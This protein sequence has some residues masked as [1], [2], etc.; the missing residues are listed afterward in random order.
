MN[1]LRACALLAL[2]AT[3]L[4]AC[5]GSQP[6]TQADAPV[7]GHTH[8]APYLSTSPV[9]TPTPN[10]QKLP[11]FRGPAIHT[12]ARPL[13]ITAN[14]NLVAL[15]ML[16]ITAGTADPNLDSAR[17]MLGQSGVPFDVLD[18]TTTPLTEDS[19]IAGADGSGRYQGVILTN[20]AL[21]Y[22]TD[23]GGW[24]SALSATEW[25][26]LWQYERTYHARQLSLY[27][28]P[29]SWPEDYGL[30]YV[31][32]S[33][34]DHADLSVA[35]AGG[36]VL[37]DLRAGTS[38][39]VRSAWNYPATVTPA[40]GVASVQPILTDAQGR[41][42]G[43]LSSAADGR[44]RLALTFA[45]NQYLLHTELLGADLVNWVTR[46][47]YLGEYRRYNQLDIDDWFLANDR[48][49]PASGNVLPDATRMAPSDA[50]SLRDQ[51]NAI[52]AGYDT[53]RAFRF[54]IFFNGGGANTGAPKSC[55]P[56]VGGPD[57]LTS[58]SKCL[59]GTFDWVSHT[60][61]HEY[62]DSLNYD[63]SYQQLA[64]NNSIGA[65][66]GLTRSAG[67]LTTGDMSGLGYY[68]KGGDGPKTDYGLSASNPA[69]LQAAEKAGVRYL[70]SNH[71]VAS[72]WDPSCAGCGIFH[73]LKPSILLVPRWPT[74]MFYDA[75]NPTEISASYNSVYGPGGT[76]AYW[77]HALSYAEI[78]DKE[79]DIALSHVLAGGAYP[80][81]MHTANLYQYAPGKSVAGDW[82]N[83]LLTK[84]NRYSTLPLNTL[85][86]DDLGAYMSRRTTFMKSNVRA[87]V[88]YGAGTVTLTSPNGG[89]A[90]VSG[91]TGGATTVYGGRPVSSW[92]LAPGQ[93]LT[94]AL[95]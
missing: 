34:S 49:D 87:L 14:P 40:D 33:A 67:S 2:T 60:R 23:T 57:P 47:L 25:A 56:K 9:V 59:S 93:S 63:Q 65:A 83:A 42:M 10:L 91:L 88:N 15:K 27:T 62:M 76:F 84:Y 70:A 39:P 35:A 73:P 71:S 61:D 86:W 18:A 32:G 43:A 94:V 90:F 89:A 80:H 29:G 41:V 77:D 55:D 45:H 1:P 50:L 75:A 79:T 44:E 8:V 12:P 30:R 26:T 78:L 66:L 22:Q 58:A 37:G 51:Q 6:A 11:N 64:G 48:Y 20:N 3:L 95:K 16:V 85:K 72:Q 36:G 92:T 54:S 13:S 7:A 31:D 53:A 81:Y 74:N 19:L 82:E 38:L 21:L 24:D 28:F 52:R 69:F 17:A 68:N 46:G 4:A 5:G